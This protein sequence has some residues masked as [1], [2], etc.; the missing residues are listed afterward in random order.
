MSPEVQRKL[1]G[2][3]LLAGAVGAFWLLSKAPQ[4]TVLVLEEEDAIKKQ[5]PV[6]SNTTPT[7]VDAFSVGSSMGDAIDADFRVLDLG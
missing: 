4:P 7:T 5:N 6:S 3:T 2:V 1:I